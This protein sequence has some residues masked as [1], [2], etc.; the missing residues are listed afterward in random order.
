MIYFLNYQRSWKKSLNKIQGKIDKLFD[1]LSEYNDESLLAF[2]SLKTRL[3]YYLNLTEKTF[4]FD[5]IKVNKMIAPTLNDC[6][7][8]AHFNADVFNYNQSTFL[9]NPVGKFRESMEKFEFL[10]A[11]QPKLETITKFLT[12]PKHERFKLVK[13][14]SPRS[15]Y[16]TKAVN[17]SDG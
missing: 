11:N 16:E 8:L 3:D 4:E 10:A 7:N 15:P 14:G 12:L 1:Q 9:N 6:N 13:T 2:E 17:K 5:I